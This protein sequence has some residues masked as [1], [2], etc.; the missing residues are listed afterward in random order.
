[1]TITCLVVRLSVEVLT[2]HQSRSTD[3]PDFPDADNSI[4]PVTKKYNTAEGCVQKIFTA[5]GCDTDI[6][7]A[8]GCVSF[9]LALDV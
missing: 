7:T 4:A 6:N 1:M 3:L 2:W 9:K 5:E 8:E